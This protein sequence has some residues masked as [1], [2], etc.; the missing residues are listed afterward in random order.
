[1]VIATPTTMLALLRT[2]RYGY[3]RQDL[4]QNAE[5]IRELA[6]KLLKRIGKV[7]EK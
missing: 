2:I 7:H 5:E 3:D 1:M 6:G 4:A